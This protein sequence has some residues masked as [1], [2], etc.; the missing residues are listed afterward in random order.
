MGYLQYYI[1]DCSDKTED[2]Y[3]VFCAKYDLKEIS[4]CPECNTSVYFNIICDVEGQ[5]G[6]HCTILQCPKCNEIVIER[7]QEPDEDTEENIIIGI[8]PQKAKKRKFGKVAADIS[9]SFVTVYNQAN[10]AEAY[11]LS[12]I[13]GMG[14]RKA[15]EYLIKDYAIKI[16]PEN[17]EEIKKKALSKCIDDYVAEPKIKEMAKRAVWLGNDETHYV[18]KWVDK[19]ITDMKN[20]IDLTLYWMD[21]ERMTK[22]YK[23]TMKL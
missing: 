4:E 14:Y 3:K 1:E 2:T 21:F 16:Y 8:Y 6:D 10:A 7:W 11:N 13:A 5:E 12:E 9:P 15:M 18:K 19:D 17:K 22:E 20:L 23:E